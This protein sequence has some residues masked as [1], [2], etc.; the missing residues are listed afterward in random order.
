MMITPVSVLTCSAMQGLLLCM[1]NS[2]FAFFMFGYQIH[3]KAVL[4]LLLPVTL[5]ADA[6]PFLSA[7]LPPVA[8]FSMWPLLSRDGLQLAYPAT[9]LLFAAVV[10]TR[11]SADD[12]GLLTT[13]SS[14]APQHTAASTKPRSSAAHATPPRTRSVF[15]RAPA[16]AVPCSLLGAALLH[17][18]QSVMPPSQRYPYLMDAL[19]TSYAFVHLALAM[20]YLNWRQWA[21]GNHVKLA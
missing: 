17:V 14:V 9:I 8:A 6:E 19:F 21:S 1:A 2:A 3:E 11:A 20:L 7:A 15:V 16:Y 12:G 5:L 4:L 18:V 13:D 10:G